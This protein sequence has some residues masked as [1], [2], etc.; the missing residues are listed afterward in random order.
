[1]LKKYF[2][3]LIILCCLWWFI[4]GCTTKKNT[5]I[6]RSYHNLTSFYNVYYNARESFNQGIKKL[7]QNYQ[8][9]YA[10]LLPIYKSSDD[11]LAKS[12]AP[13]MNKTIEKCAKTIRKHSITVKPKAKEGRLSPKEKEFYER[14]D[15]CNQIDDAY[16]LMG[17]ANY[18][19][20][21]YFAALETF[22]YVV[23]QFAK[24]PVKYEA[25]YWIAR[26]YN[27]MKKYND[28]RI[29]LDML[30]GDKLTPANL[31]PQLALL[32]AD[33]N[34][35]QGEYEKAAGLIE[36]YLKFKP[37]P[38]KKERIRLLYILGQVYEKLNQNQKALEYYSEVLTLNPPY[39][40]TFNAQ[41]NV[42]RMYSAQSGDSREIKKRLNKML[43]DD[44]NIDYLDQIY[45]ALANISYN[46]NDEENAVQYYLTSA[47]K[48]TK[49]NTQKGLSFLALAD[50]Y[51]VKPDYIKAQMYYDSTITF[52][53]K[54]FP[55]FENIYVKTQTLTELVS[56]I[57]TIEKEDSLQ[58]I[59]KMTDS[60]R[61]KIID[62]IIRKIKE[63]EERKKDEMNQNRFDA[64]VA[65]QTTSNLAQQGGG[66][67]YFYN[68]STLSTGKAGF[69]K[70]WGNR[71]LED[72]WR[73]KNKEIVADMAVSGTN[74]SDTAKNVLSNTSREY[75]LRDLPLN[76]SLMALS[77]TRIQ[78]AYFKTALVYKEKL[79]NY[80]ESVRYLETLNSRFPKGIL[81]LPAYYN[82]FK[83]KSL[84]KDET[85]S[86][87][88]KSKIISEYPESNYARMLL[89]PEY[90]KELAEQQERVKKYYNE[91]YNLY[92]GKQ[93]KE[94]AAGISKSD[95]LFPENPIRPKFMLL[96]AFITGRLTADT[97]AFTT[98]LGKIVKA[99]PKSD[100]AVMA[101]EIIK[102]LIK[103]KE[104]KPDIFAG[105]PTDT[106]SLL[107][108]VDYQVKDESTHYF[109][110]ALNSKKSL[111]NEVKFRLSNFNLD[112][113]S[114]LSF[115]IQTSPLDAT[116]DLVVVKSFKNK[117]QGMNYFESVVS[118]EGVI[119][120]DIVPD[121]FRYFIITTENY[122]KLLKDKRLADY[123]DFFR[124]NYLPGK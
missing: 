18:Y 36:K 104:V 3:S 105:Q 73:R 44:K 82:L 108:K 51:F 80:I 32:T 54:D 52:L 83:I 77:N 29:F 119:L 62:E 15:Y 10:V 7:D 24:Q 20:H 65:Q 59:A 23:R 74:A 64:M 100:E 110:I 67:W 75:Y 58:R 79:N 28:T 118:E 38:P 43:K 121:D 61:N 37:V 48:S 69:L 81:E 21:D 92:I 34:L 63:E 88:Y 91:V 41:V 8:E 115:N 117:N 93:Y 56:G 112:F 85:G 35:K 98:A 42:A 113:F 9:N 102:T 2:L 101:T 122:G 33:Y 53:S 46:E 107:P 14:P 5:T 90:F 97:L 49:N 99:F 94:A 96:D 123:L 12:I 13:Q 120:Q 114:L 4:P 55:D 60:E 6:T 84:Q 116:F 106:T 47:A 30:N 124:K 39:E 27:E 31:K 45:Y 68:P 50:I 25:L 1:M 57:K 40:M 70:K 78:D 66:K 95:D 71:K 26:T 76:D 16:L 103:P 19:K 17:K 22:N 86:N 109:I 87:L 89:N 111:S 11:N 72:H